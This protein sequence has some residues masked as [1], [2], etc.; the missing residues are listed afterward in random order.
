MKSMLLQSV[1]GHR[2]TVIC[3]LSTVVFVCSGMVCFQPLYAQQAP[4]YKE[5]QDFKKQDSIK[6]PPQHA[7]L[8]VGS[9]SFQN[10]PRF[11]RLF[12]A[13]CDSLYQ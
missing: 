1:I 8:F 6:P 12:F 11:R 4:F 7:I 2:S 9:S 13:G 10:Q 3:Y 5:I